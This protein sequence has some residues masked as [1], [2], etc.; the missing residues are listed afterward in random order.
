MPTASAPND[1]SRLGEGNDF[2][3]YRGPSGSTYPTS[4]GDSG[5]FE[6]S[7]GMEQPS[8]WLHGNDFNSMAGD[9]FSSKNGDNSYG[10]LGN[11]SLNL[12]QIK[13]VKTRV[14]M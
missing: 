5:A 14:F 10:N 7:L 11:L 13:I 9:L 3:K 4:Y 12:D 1:Y 2:F 8:S 6:P